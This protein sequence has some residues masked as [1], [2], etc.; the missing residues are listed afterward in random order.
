MSEIVLQF[1]DIDNVLADAIIMVAEAVVVI[2]ISES[3]VFSGLQ[4]ASR[5]FFLTIIAEREM[6][7][8]S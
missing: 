4:N 3:G 8:W 6:T 2:R 7:C 5:F 1:C